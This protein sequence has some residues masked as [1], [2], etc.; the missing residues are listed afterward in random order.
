ML[1]LRLGTLLAMGRWA[2]AAAAGERDLNFLRSAPFTYLFLA[3]FE[4]LALTPV[5]STFAY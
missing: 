2:K 4:P 1:V 3:F 5:R